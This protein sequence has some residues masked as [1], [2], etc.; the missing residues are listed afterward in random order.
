MFDFPS[1][2]VI[3]PE[4]YIAILLKFRVQERALRHD[5]HFKK[6][7][8]EEKGKVP[9]I[10]G[11]AVGTKRTQLFEFNSKVARAINISY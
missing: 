5:G 1:Q 3:Y 2:I 6:T 11:G 10:D 7:Q 8:F 9:D 4:E